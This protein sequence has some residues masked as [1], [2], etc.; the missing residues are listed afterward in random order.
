MDNIISFYQHRLNL[1]KATFLRI[2][3]EDAI[4]A[5]V[6]KIIHRILYT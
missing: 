1:Q 5:I 3:H 2:E 6:F 4:I